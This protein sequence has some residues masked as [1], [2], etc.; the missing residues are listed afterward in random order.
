M[1]VVE[2]RFTPEEAKQAKEAFLSAATGAGVPIIAIDG[3]P[4]GDGKLGPVTR[5]VQEAYE[6]WA[7]NH[8]ENAKNRA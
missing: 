5:K 2:R 7:A 6:D 1:K 3:V 8:A 4:I